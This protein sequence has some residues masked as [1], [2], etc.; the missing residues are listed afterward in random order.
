MSYKCEDTMHKLITRH[1]KAFTSM[2]FVYKGT[3]YESTPLRVSTSLF[4]KFEYTDPYSVWCYPKTLDYPAK[5][6][7]K[8]PLSSRIFRINQDT[9]TIKTYPVI[10]RKQFCKCLNLKTKECK[11][12]DQRPIYCVFHPLNVYTGSKIGSLNRLVNLPSPLRMDRVTLE[13]VKG[14]GF[15]WITDFDME[16]HKIE[17]I[18]KLVAMQKFMKC[19]KLPTKI[20]PVIEWVISGP[21]KE[22]VIIN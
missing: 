6:R 18:S 7:T 21:H 20:T 17:I 9:Y 13:G 3:R 10:N 4:R 11:I 12:Q 1:F 5:T 8:I 14:V 15:T 22:S 2:P 19:F 16:K